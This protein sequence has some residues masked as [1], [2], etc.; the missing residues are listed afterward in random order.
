MSYI[1]GNIPVRKYLQA[2][3]SDY[4]SVFQ[5]LSPVCRIAWK[6]S[7]NDLVMS[8]ILRQIDDY[9]IILCRKHDDSKLGLVGVLI[10]VI[11]IAIIF[12]GELGG[13]AAIESLLPTLSSGFVIANYYLYSFSLLILLVPYIII[14]GFI[15][16]YVGIFR[17]TR[18]YMIRK[19]QLAKEEEQMEQFLATAATLKRKKSKM[20]KTKSGRFS[21]A[22]YSP[23]SSSYDVLDSTTASAF[24]QSSLF[25]RSKTMLRRQS[26]KTVNA[27]AIH[28]EPK[29]QRESK[30]AKLFNT[31]FV[32]SAGSAERRS[33]L[34]SEI[35]T[36]VLEP[37][38]V[39]LGY[40]AN[41]GLVFYYAYV[42]KQKLE[43]QN[44][45][46]MMN[47]PLHLQARTTFSSR[48]EDDA[49]G[50]EDPFVS[51][52]EEIVSEKERIEAPATSAEQTKE[53]K[54]LRLQE[55]RL[56]KKE[57]MKQ[58]FKVQY[59]PS[60]SSD[61]MSALE[62]V[63]NQFASN[64]H[65]FSIHE[66]DGNP[67]NKIQ[68]L[69]DDEED[70]YRLENDEEGELFEENQDNDEEKADE[71]EKKDSY[72]HEMD[73]TSFYI[74][75][76]EESFGYEQTS[77]FRSPDNLSEHDLFSGSYIPAATT[78]NFRL[79]EYGLMGQ[80]KS[81]HSM[82]QQKKSQ[83]SFNFER[84]REPATTAGIAS[85]SN[86]NLTRAQSLL[87]KASLEEF[88]DE[89]RPKHFYK[90]MSHLTEASIV[91]IQG[92]DD[93]SID[94]TPT[95]RNQ[96][97]PSLN[98][99]KVDR[100]TQN[101]ASNSKIKQRKSSL[102]RGS[103]SSTPTTL[104]RQIIALKY[105]APLRILE[106]IQT[107]RKEDFRGKESSY[108]GF[109]INDDGLAPN[110]QYNSIMFTPS[111]TGV[112]NGYLTKLLNK[113]FFRMPD[114]NLL[115]EE[116]QLKTEELEAMEGMSN[117]PVRNT[118]GESDVMLST[119]SINDAAAKSALKPQLSMV[120]SDPNQSVLYNEDSFELANPLFKK[121]SSLI[122]PSSRTAQRQN[123]SP[124][125]YR[126]PSL[127]IG[128][129]SSAEG[130]DEK[131]QAAPQSRMFSKP[132]SLP[133]LSMNL[134][135]APSAHISWMSPRGRSPTSRSVMGTL[136]PKFHPHSR[137]GFS[138]ATIYQEEQHI[139]SDIHTAIMQ[140]ITMYLQLLFPVTSENYEILSMIILFH[141]L[142]IPILIKDITLLL[143]HIWEVYYP[144]DGI[145]LTSSEKHLINNEF[146]EFILIYYPDEVMME[147][148][149][150]I[151][152]FQI[153]MIK[154]MKYHIFVLKKR[155]LDNQSNSDSHHNNQSQW[156]RSTATT[157]KGITASPHHSFGGQRSHGTS[158]RQINYEQY[159][160]KQLLH[161]IT[162]KKRQLQ[163]EK[164]K[165]FF[166][167]LKKQNSLRTSL[168]LNLAG[169][170]AV[171][172]QQH[173]DNIMP[174]M[175][176]KINKEYR[177]SRRFDLISADKKVASPQR[178]SQSSSDPNQ[179]K[180]QFKGLGIH[181]EMMKHL[182][183]YHMTDEK[184]TEEDEAEVGDAA[185]PAND[186]HV[187]LFKTIYERQL[188][189][190]RE[191][192]QQQLIAR[193]N[194]P[195]TSPS[196]NDRFIRQKMHQTRFITDSIDLEEEKDNENDENK[197]QDRQEE[198]EEMEDQLLMK[199]RSA[200]DE[201]I[202]NELT[203]LKELERLDDEAEEDDS[204]DL[205]E[206]IRRNLH[207]RESIETTSSSMM[208]TP[209]GNFVLPI[210]ASP[211]DD[212]SLSESTLSGS[213]KLSPLQGF[214]KG[215][216]K[217]QE[218]EEV[219]QPLPSLHM[220]PMIANEADYLP[221]AS[222]REDENDRVWYVNHKLTEK[223]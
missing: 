43:E 128:S 138:V 166:E 156:L 72:D 122:K 35:Y 20:M 120:P 71:D 186:P 11:P 161:T 118:N 61:T 15:V 51:A 45:W 99:R 198:E 188:L 149:I 64:I 94:S 145:P 95:A 52:S 106:S 203:L 209:S 100:L 78:T 220:T 191:R 24:A 207:Q 179:K 5:H 125:F 16:W 213:Y 137:R 80:S 170:A 121:N 131:P 211:I 153:I 158:S 113:S 147:L 154:F 26:E 178:D 134:T 180:P 65:T 44:S 108:D 159:F 189:E 3:T 96:P 1:Q 141:D 202:Q 183:R 62:Q 36:S 47:L 157:P 75:R 85:N 217:E 46:R 218:E 114:M 215:S 176:G 212:V 116:Y 105:G 67:E 41:P 40:F 58:L 107:N 88:K 77:L 197:E 143:S 60:H 163:K 98:R 165:M 160:S 33:N 127:N 27:E 73:I 49:E 42:Q 90:L 4:F 8:K 21:D 87:R 190:L 2:S 162:K 181:D 196:T 129:F 175:L 142:Q 117:K 59:A 92:D 221:A 101:V 109:M 171:N 199:I 124:S 25:T 174:P 104:P 195:P 19:S 54:A 32:S 66:G 39:G 123:H 56:R 136:K 37:M 222:R 146:R 150:F 102:H 38:L 193:I 74:T 168:A 7:F 50:L 164:Q 119:T 110:T 22:S 152:W 53:R 23:A 177:E 216:R 111:N 126:V 10:V 17:S 172:Q 18:K 86:I 76:E 135:S 130:E 13:E 210:V 82:Y 57:K 84:L 133:R 81:Q 9:D 219:Q 14:V 89:N 184:K 31:L 194:L 151:E 182:S 91:Q 148:K 167:Q 30:I 205:E 48:S 132:F 12:F 185:L 115:D 34:A 206:E 192:Y 169:D 140:F 79:R 28:E 173:D 204:F 223:H 69:G 55:E 93:F 214:S 68:Q 103:V 29:V 201:R 70:D 97:R 155:Y 63:Q 83:S 144:I 112:G 6:E 208:S 139:L 187:H 200:I